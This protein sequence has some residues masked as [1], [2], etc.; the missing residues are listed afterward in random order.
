MKQGHAMFSSLKRAPVPC[1][2][3]IVVA[4]EQQKVLTRGDRLAGAVVDDGNALVLGRAC[5]GVGH[6]VATAHHG[7][8][9]A[10]HAC[11]IAT[12]PS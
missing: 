9:S 12:S 10:L 1:R 3:V 4:P 11:S 2:N 5:V 7:A 6:A 8:V